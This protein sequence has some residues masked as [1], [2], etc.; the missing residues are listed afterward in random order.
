MFFFA[1]F[2]KVPQVD[3]EDSQVK[4]TAYHIEND[5]HKYFSFSLTPIPDDQQLFVK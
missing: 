3:K 4:K 2:H 5:I 1:F